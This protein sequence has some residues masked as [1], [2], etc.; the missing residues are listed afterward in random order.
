M[1]FTLQLREIRRTGK[2]KAQKRAP[3]K[4][5]AEVEIQILK[6]NAPVGGDCGGVTANTLKSLGEES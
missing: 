1:D 5:A 3:W 2:A 6:M 4:A